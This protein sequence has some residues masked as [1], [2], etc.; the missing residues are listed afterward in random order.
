MGLFEESY[1]RYMTKWKHRQDIRQLIENH[2]RIQDKNFDKIKLHNYHTIPLMND[3][4][5]PFTNYNRDAKVH[6]TSE[7]FLTQVK[8]KEI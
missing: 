7:F 4:L 8:N 5:T 3:S 6:D 2:N 1:L